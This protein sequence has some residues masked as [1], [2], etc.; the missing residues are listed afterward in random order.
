MKR[1]ELLRKYYYDYGWTIIPV[2]TGEKRPGLNEWKSYQNKKPTV[3]ELRV[4]FK[5]PEVGVGL[6]TGRQSGVVVIDEDSYKEKGVEVKLNSPLI[7]KTGG[8]GRHLYFRYTEGLTNAVNRDKAIDVRGEGGFVVLPP[9]KHPSGNYYEWLT[10]LP[11]NLSNLPTLDESFAEEIAKRPTHQQ[12]I[13]INEYMYV[14]EGSRNDSLHRIACSLLNKMSEADTFQTLLGINQ[15]YDPPLSEREVETTFKSALAFVRAHPK[16][17]FKEKIIAE[18]KKEKEEKVQENMRVYSFQEAEI[19]YEELMKRYGNGV[20]TGYNI[21]DE[22]FSFL[23]QNL[24]M[25]SA[26]THIGKTTLALNMAGRVAR[27]GYKVLFASLEQ[28]VFIIPRLRSMFGT[29]ERLNN[30]SVIAP[31]EMPKPDDLLMAVANLPEKPKLLI[32][33]HL[34]YFERGMKGAT[35]EIDRLIAKLQMVANKTELPVVVVAHV[36][37]L[38]A[39]RGQKEKPP[40]MDDLKDSSSL[41]QIP[42]VV[43]MLHRERNDDESIQRGEGILKNEGALFIYKNRIHG[44]TGS[45]NF[46]IYDNGE[47]VFDRTPGDRIKTEAIPNNADVIVGLEGIA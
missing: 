10:E 28:S 45:E 22:Y 27:A 30:I 34:H 23:P 1:N 18:Q 21:L 39:A 15:N 47:I 13:D 16:E 43:A 36:R 5:D 9:T 40:S 35:E 17:T 6:I 31:P 11:D 2:K 41:S 26:A 44:K 14:G 37:K 3:E 24:Y 12:G 46:T 33:D 4:W 42:S 32:I 25:I 19:K 29:E 7:V 20:T 8:G 38:S